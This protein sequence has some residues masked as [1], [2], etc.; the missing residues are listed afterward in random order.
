MTQARRPDGSGGPLSENERIDDIQFYTD[1][2]AEL[3]IDDIVLYDASE[4][5][6]EAFP[7]RPIF[8]GWFD[9]GRKGRDWPGE[10]EIVKHDPPGA[11]KAARSQ[12]DGRLR[13]QLRGKRP[14]SDRV[15]LRFRYRLKSGNRVKVELVHEGKVVA[16]ADVK[17]AGSGSWESAKIAFS[18]P[19]RYAEE[20]RFHVP[21]GG[22]LEVD[23]VLLYVP[24]RN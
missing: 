9:T 20:V 1:P 13:I 5:A 2:S 3:V 10:F 12:E 24:S 17:P 7:D 8:T 21:S 16:A 23:D 11:W 4:A 22:R 15:A 6:V 19:G 14:L 18:S